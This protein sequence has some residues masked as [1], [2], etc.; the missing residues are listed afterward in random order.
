MKR[1]T[2]LAL[3][4]L[5]SAVG[6]EK[7]DEETNSD[8][9][10]GVTMF[11]DDLSFLREHTD[12]VVLSD[13]SGMSRV[14]VSPALQGRVLT[15]TARGDEGLSYGWINRELIASGER[16]EH[17]NAFGGEDRFWIGPEGGQYSIYFAPGDPFDLEHWQ[18]PAEFDWEPFEV[19][20][21]SRE[22]V[23]FE[24][25]MELTN[26]SETEFDLNVRREVRLLDRAEAAEE[27][28][29]ALDTA[30][31]VVAFESAN[32]MSNTG[33]AAWTK[34]GGL[35]SVWI[36]GMFNPSPATTVVVPYREGPE[37]ELGPIV[38]D[39]YFG[40]V[41]DDRLRDDDGV[42]Y[43][44]GDG[45]YRSKIGLSKS[46]SRPILGSYDAKNQ[47]LTLVQYTLPGGEEDYVNSMWEIQDDPYGGDVVNSYNDG[48]P[49]P[50][51]EP[52][53]PFYELES[54]SPAAA[55]APGDSLVHVHRTVHIQGSR[56][57]LDRIARAALGRSLDAIEG[58]F[59]SVS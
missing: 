22:W 54:S 39:E 14:A 30:V 44:S 3:I 2:L 11:G 57:E 15:S 4:A 40:K 13:E 53:G 31:S 45:E 20:E 37:S 33:D 12:V 41:P 1:A 10:A 52:M 27:F 25:A 48:P 36:L 32:T 7:A 21:Q 6:C 24:K 5:A 46:R 18:V 35:L 56:E 29:V 17:I 47:V 26:Y 19:V 9:P 55:L 28:G 16:Q 50:G 51:A 34:E 42:L 49:A 59:G 38:N 23:V 58:A 43:F 8:Q